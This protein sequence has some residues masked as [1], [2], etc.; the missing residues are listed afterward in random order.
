MFFDACQVSLF[1]F[2]ETL[3]NYS[4]KFSFFTQSKTYKFIGCI[5]KQQIMIT[6]L[7]KYSSQVA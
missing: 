1:S 6:M 4:S 7:L 2:N 3:L 5:W